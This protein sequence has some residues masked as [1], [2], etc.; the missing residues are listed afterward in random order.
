MDRTPP[1]TSRFTATNTKKQRRQA[2]ASRPTRLSFFPPTRICSR[3]RDESR[4]GTTRVSIAGDVA[5]LRSSWTF[6]GTK[7]AD[8]PVEPSGETVEVLRRRANG[9]GL[10]VIDLPYGSE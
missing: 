6:S 7:L 3:L 10:V 5:L 4:R 9:S 8:E 1:I 2:P